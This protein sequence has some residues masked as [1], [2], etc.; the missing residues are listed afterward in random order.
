MSDA[1][2]IMA[3]AAAMERRAILRAYLDLSAEDFQ[4][5][6][7]VRCGYRSDVLDL[8]AWVKAQRHA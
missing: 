6:L 5:W 3:D 1:A 4:M 8:S 7:Y 2:M